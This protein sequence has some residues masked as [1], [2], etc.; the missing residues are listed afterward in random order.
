MFLKNTAHD[1]FDAA[2]LLNTLLAGQRLSTPAAQQLMDHILQQAIPD[3]VL[4]AL[5]MVLRLQGEDEALLTGFAR[6]LRQH[7]TSIALPAGCHAMDTCGT[8]GDGLHT[9]NVSTAVALVL[10]SLEI[11]V[12]KHGNRAVSSQAGSAD[13]LE[14][15]GIPLHHDADAALRGL[16]QDHFAFCFAPAFHPALKAVAPLRRRLKTRTAFNLLG[17]LCNPGQVRRQIL[18]VSDVKYLMPLARTLQGLDCESALVLCAE[19]G[20][21]E[22]SL[23]GVSHGVYLHKGQLQNL[24]FT[25]EAAGLSRAPLAAVVGGDAT[26]NARLLQAVFRGEGVQAHRDLILYNVAAA[27]MVYG[28]TRDLKLGVAL[29]ADAIDKGYVQRKI[30]ALQAVAEVS[31]MPTTAVK[32]VAA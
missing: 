9:F 10:A 13:V 19:D 31:E 23:A 20:M 11:P 12:L 21:D 1:T 8:G 3:D 22:L 18:G 32:A 14:A 30:S 29:A 16:Q 4:S 17:P 26:H 27:L 5:L 24:S 6:S 28:I 7:G 15:L 2:V 25:P